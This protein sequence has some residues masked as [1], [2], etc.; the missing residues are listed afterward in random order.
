MQSGF[1]LYQWGCIY[2]FQNGTL[3]QKPTKRDTREP[4]L[5]IKS[6]L[7]EHS[8]QTGEQLTKPAAKSQLLFNNPLCLY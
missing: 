2:G 5:K 3:S 1:R 8:M 4:R 6:M 7:I